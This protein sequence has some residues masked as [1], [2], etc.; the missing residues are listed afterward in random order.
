M[1]GASLI[2]LMHQ[3]SKYILAYIIIIFALGLQFAE[4][5]MRKSDV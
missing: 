3:Q 2:W 4:A 1:N 5:T